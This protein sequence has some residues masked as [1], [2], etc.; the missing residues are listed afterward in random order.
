MSN[1]HPNLKLYLKFDT[2]SHGNK[3]EDKSGNGHDATVHGA[4]LIDDE[5]FGKCL[6]FDGKKDF[7]DCGDQVI[8]GDQF[9]QELWIYPQSTDLKFYGILGSRP[10]SKNENRSPSIWVGGDRQI[11]AGFGDGKSWKNITTSR[12]I[13]FNSWNHLALTFDGRSYQVYVNG[14]SVFALPITGKPVTRPIKAIGRVNNFFNG[15]IAHVRMYNR[16]LSVAEV[17]ADLLKDQYSHAPLNV[18]SPIDFNLFDDEIQNV[19][20]ISNDSAENECHLVIKNISERKLVLKPLSKKV[21]S[22]SNYHFALNFR[23]NTFPK[24]KLPSLKEKGSLWKSSVLENKQNNEQIVYLLYTGMDDLDLHPMNGQKF[25][26]AYQSADGA[27]GSR[28]TRVMLNYQNIKDSDIEGTLSGESLVQL[29]IINQRGKKNIPLHIGFVGSNTILNDSDPKNKNSGTAGSLRIRIMNSMKEG[30]LAFRRTNSNGTNKSRFIVTFGDPNSDWALFD[31]NKQDQVKKGN[32][33]ST[34]EKPTK[35]TVSKSSSQGKTVTFNVVPTVEELDAGDHLEFV[36]KDF[37]S[38]K[39]SGPANIYIHYED[40]PGYWDGM[41]VLVAE[42]TP[43]SHR[44]FGGLKNVGI[45]IEPDGNNQL[46]VGGV[47]Q[48]DKYVVQ[49]SVNGGPTKG[50]WMWN[51]GDSN[52]G[53]YMGQAGDKRSLAGN[54][55]VAGAGFSSHAIRIRTYRGQNNGLIYENSNEQLNLS[56]RGSDGLT[57]IRG[58]VGIG[59]TNPSQKLMVQGNHTT[60]KDPQSGLTYGGSLA[61]KGKGPAIDFID[62]GHNDWSI[63]V[64]SNKMYFVRQPWNYTDLVLDGRGN[65]GIGTDSP[66]QK[67]VVQ[68]NHSTK[69]DPQSGLTYGGS[70]AIKGKGPTID[71]IDTDHN[72]W[73]IHVNSNKMYFVRQPWNY[74]DLVLDGR[75]NVGIGTDSPGG[76][77][78]VRGE[79]KSSSNVHVGGRLYVNSEIKSSSNVRVGRTL[80]FDAQDGEYWYIYP[81]S[82]DKPDKDLFFNFSG[83]PS[84]TVSG[85]L[86]PYGKGWKNSSDGRLKTDIEEIDGILDKVVEL[87]PSFFRFKDVPEK[88]Q[89]QIGFIAQDVEKIFPDLVTEKQGF[90]GLA[91][92]DFGVLAIAAIKEQQSAITKLQQEIATLKKISKVR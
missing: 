46:K 90:K 88:K 1:A 23:P 49:D 12:V 10:R 4:Q 17:K 6:K 76:K 61:I 75:G 54:K 21:P 48:A 18:I 26:L 70:L 55:A 11:S 89:K 87:K 92:T 80:I 44:S 32:P 73:S 68:G 85:W 5:L 40:I 77:L 2:I 82:S 7:V 64:N 45:G 34:V 14:L 15:N 86:E 67:L 28:A 38:S 24:G 56:V 33:N 51:I 22:A 39:P 58:N 25:T 84:N 53:I 47:L 50:I 42:K 62:T 91:Y 3:I 20:Y 59:I 9:T 74:T 19:L 36:L 37:R 29:D 30:T 78:D 35:C 16:A 72:D 71:F 63:H 60:K 83:N 43:I 52:W 8:L 13:N 69:K 31:A 27:L 57:Y 81:Q 65:V 41:F 66:S 79:I